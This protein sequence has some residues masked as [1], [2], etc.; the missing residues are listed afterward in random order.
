[1]KFEGVLLVSVVALSLNAVGCASRS[2]AGLDPVHFKYD[3]S[4]LT[5]EAKSVIKQNSKMI[6]TSKVSGKILVE[7]HTDERG[8]SEYN[9]V[10]GERRA[11]ATRDFLIA[12]GV[13]ASKILVKSWGEERPES[14]GQTEKAFAKNRRAE[15][16]ASIQDED[17]DKAQQRN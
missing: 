17:L 13:P 9:I 10:L 15:F 12:Q 2:A 8:T 11:K 3:N 6:K 16:V 5:K 7:G 1:M 14:S 4:E